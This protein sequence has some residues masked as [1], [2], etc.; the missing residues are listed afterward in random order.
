MNEVKNMKIAHLIPQFY[1][2]VG[3]AEICIHNVCRTLVDEGHEAVIVTTAY[4]PDNKL[5]LPYEVVALWNRTSGLMKKYPLIGKQYLLRKLAHLQKEHKF[6]L[7]QVTAGYPLGIYAVDF[8]RKNNIPCILRCCGE[9]IQKFPQIDYGYRLDPQVDSL[10]KS[11]FPLFN[12]FVALTETVREEYL[13]LGINEENIRIIPNGAD[14]AK[15]AKARSNSDKICEIRRKYNVGDKKLILTT[16]RYHSK[17]GFD[18]IP[19]IAKIL[20]DRG[21]DFIWIV[22]G[23]QTSVLKEKYSESKELGIVCSE[24][25]TRSD[26]EDA[27]SLPPDS[28]VELYCAADLFVLPTLIETFGMVLVEAM[29]AGLPILTTD[30]PGV[31]DVIEEGENGIKLPVQDN[32]AMAEKIIEVLANN[33]F[34]ERLSKTSLEMA[35]EVY[36]WKVVTGKYIEFYEQLIS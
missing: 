1:P 28:L 14:F 17:K 10:V 26:S 5:K 33:T 34:A 25:Y 16:G 7:W 2:Y 3:G 36:D 20:K 21:E 35:E 32:A 29:A 12:G 31:K 24:E 11:Q 4:K 18:L 8:F 15:F 13:E 9:D 30:A 23:R 19:A 6:D 22:A 27:F